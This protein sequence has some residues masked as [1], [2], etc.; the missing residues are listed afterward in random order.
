M[1]SYEILAQKY[2]AEIST[3]IFNLA[4]KALPSQHE[5]D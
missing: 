1:L 5:Y 2:F 3:P 4:R